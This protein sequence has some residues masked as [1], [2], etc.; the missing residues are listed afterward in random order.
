[1][2]EEASLIARAILSVDVVC[3]PEV[4]V[5][6][7]GIGANPEL[8]EPVRRAVHEVSPFPIRIERSAGGDR[9]GLLGATAL[10]RQRGWQL[11]F[12]PMTEKQEP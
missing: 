7:G 10:A 11:L 2:A 8:L 3:D 1:M 9:S 12:P 5:L 6:A 4:F